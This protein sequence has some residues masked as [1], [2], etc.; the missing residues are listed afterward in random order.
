MGLSTPA[1]HH[2]SPPTNPPSTRVQP[3]T[4]PSTTTNATAPGTGQP[5]AT[6]SSTA[7]LLLHQYQQEARREGEREFDAGVGERQR[8]Q[9]TMLQRDGGAAL[10]R[11]RRKTRSAYVS[12]YASKAYS[13]LLELHITR[14]HQ[15]A[16]AA[17]SALSEQS[18]RHA[19]VRQLIEKMEINLA[20]LGNGGAGAVVGG[21]APQQPQTRAQVLPAQVT[22]HHKPRT[23]SVPLL[24]RDQSSSIPNYGI[25]AAQPSRSSHSLPLPPPPVS[26][27]LPLPQL[28]RTSS[29]GTNW[30]PI[31]L[32][33]TSGAV[34]GRSIMGGAGQST[35][36]PWNDVLD[37]AMGESGGK[38]TAASVSDVSGSEPEE[39]RSSAKTNTARATT[40]SIGNSVTTNGGNG[41]T[42]ATS[43]SSNGVSR[44]RTR[45]LEAATT[46]VQ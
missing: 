17:R 42:T 27:A 39:T 15:D 43:G 21:S 7:S 46:R 41:G 14:E 30:N 3:P 12:R 25:Q 24:P 5:N 8:Q 28:P 2:F 20:K 4:T 40:A 37:N 36:P 22:Q 26:H 18:E 10:A 45:R 44:T 1:T 23:G 13:K 6:A 34:Q 33:P 35:R 31:A 29:S 38:K 11:K 19:R 9:D 16:T 32:L